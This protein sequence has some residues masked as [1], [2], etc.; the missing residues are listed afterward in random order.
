MAN[1][2]QVAALAQEL[3]FK[4]LHEA[5]VGWEGCNVKDLTDFGN[6][7]AQGLVGKIS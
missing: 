2:M 1:Y 7:S 4:I 5:E 6:L 3:V